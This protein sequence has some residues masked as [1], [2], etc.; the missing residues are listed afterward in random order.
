LRYRASKKGII[1]ELKS[2]S[3]TDPNLLNQFLK[4]EGL[5][6]GSMEE[7]TVTKFVG[8]KEVKF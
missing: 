5:E 6:K 3:A 4:D 1:N 2:D 7:Q 8:V